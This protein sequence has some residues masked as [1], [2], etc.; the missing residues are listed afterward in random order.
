M[1]RLKISRKKLRAALLVS[2]A[3][4]VI[5]L[6]RINAHFAESTASPPA[7]EADHSKIV[8]AAIG[9]S[10]TSGIGLMTE[11]GDSSSYP[12]Q[13]QV[14]LGYSYQV[15][16]YGLSRRTLLS[17]GDAPY[18]QDQFYTDSQ[19]AQPDIV[20][21]MLGT[22]DSKAYNWNADAYESQLK[23]FVNT[24]K[25]LA[26]KPTVYLMSPPAAYQNPGLIDPATVSEQIVPIVQRVADETQVIYIDIYTAT[27]NHPDLF[28]DGI[29]PNTTGYKLIAQTVYDSLQKNNASFV[30]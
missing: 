3:V 15:I 6:L 14:L 12:S 11:N 9:D 2:I 22:N 5:A 28:P 30:R 10:N 13:L 21:I 26:S 29:H 19:Q 16:N 25:N 7:P 4:A 24:Y 23:E 18:T 1:R 8:V 27:K 17:T 20:L